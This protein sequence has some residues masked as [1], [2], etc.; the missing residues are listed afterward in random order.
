[1]ATDDKPLWTHDELTAWGAKM[2]ANGAA[3]G[4]WFALLLGAAAWAILK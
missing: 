1:M 2:F 4:F 3:C